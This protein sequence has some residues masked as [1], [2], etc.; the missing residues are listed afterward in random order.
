MLQQELCVPRMREVVILLL[1]VLKMK[2]INSKRLDRFYEQL[3][4]V[5]ALLHHVSTYLAAI[6]TIL[7]IP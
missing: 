7:T 1:L 6:F 3:E 5:K 4:D 2:V